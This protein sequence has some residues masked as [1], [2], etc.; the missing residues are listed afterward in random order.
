L[1]TV[2]RRD[3]RAVGLPA[4]AFVVAVVFELDGGLLLI[5]GFRARLVAIVLAL[6]CLAT[7]VSLHNNLADQNQMIH[8]LKNIMQAG[9][10]LQIAVITRI[11]FDIAVCYCAM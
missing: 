3:D 10:L 8:F 9:G 7:A 2:R 4:P 5:A 6:L 1:L 11:G